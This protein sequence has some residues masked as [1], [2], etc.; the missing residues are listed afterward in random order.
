[1]FFTLFAC[2]SRAQE[3]VLCYFG[4][5][6][7]LGIVNAQR[8]FG[9]RATRSRTQVEAF[10]LIELLVVIAIIAILAALLLPALNQAKGRAKRIQCVSDLKQTGLAFHVFEN[11]HNG[12]LPTQVSTNDGG[13]LE[14]VTSG[15]QVR[16]HFYY[17]FQHFL[18][19]AGALTTPKLLACP[20]DLERWA[21]TNFNEFNNWNLSYLVG[22]APSADLPDAILA[23][24]RN[25]PVCRHT[26]PGPTIGYFIA[27]TNPPPRWLT[28]LH[29]NKGNVLF[30]DGRVDESYDAILPS[31]CSVTEYMV[32]PDVKAS[33]RYSP[34]GDTINMPTLDNP[35][36]PVATPPDRIPSPPVIGKQS[37]PNPAGS[38][39][40]S[41][42]APSPSPATGPG[43]TSTRP[44]IQAG[45][46]PAESPQQVITNT[47]AA[48]PARQTTNGPAAKPGSAEEPGFSIFPTELSTGVVSVTKKGLWLL[49]LL[50]LLLAA[51][52][53][54]ARSRMGSSKS[55]KSSVT[56]DEMD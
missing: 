39:N 31:E 35:K 23:A 4:G 51:I 30:A 50:L 16:G 34:P 17:A 9:M 10:T 21:G 37:F 45:T 36:N 19:L 14:F 8:I 38:A 52:A 25:F 12:K 56:P 5:Q 26:P 44:V 54:Y 33:P 1:V 7:V 28:G 27:M 46:F 29:Q 20:A 11:D 13:S 6:K 48:T 49:W 22:L 55:P 41:L 15:F 18:P 3:S 2:P 43:I 24:D 53:V 40:L 32:Y 42:P 47:K